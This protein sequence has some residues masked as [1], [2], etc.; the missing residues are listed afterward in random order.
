MFL[1]HTV[2]GDI[3]QHVEL[4]FPGEER[5]PEPHGGAG[6]GGPLVNR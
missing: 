3:A 6:P 4:G 1:K 5:W 2:G